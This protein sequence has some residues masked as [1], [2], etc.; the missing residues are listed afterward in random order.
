MR[1]LSAA[2]SPEVSPSQTPDELYTQ[3]GVTRRVVVLCLLLAVFF[4][5]IIPIIDVK[6]QNSFLGAQHLPP[7]AIAVLLVLLLV[8]NPLMRLFAR[9]FMFSRNE[10]LTV[11]IACLFSA[12]VPGH[13]AE[14]Y[15]VPNMIGLFYFANPENRW[16]EYWGQIKSWLTPALWS[17][18]G[19]YGEG[20]RRAVEGW[21]LGNRPEEAIPWDAW[22]VPLF[23]WSALI[24]A[25]YVMLGCLSIMLRAQWSERE[26]LAFPLLRLPEEMTQDVDH[27]HIY[28][29]LGRFFR[30]PMMWI[31]FGIA[32]FIQCVNG[33][34]VYFSDVPKI[35]LSL[36]GNFF[37]EAPWNQIDQVPLQVYPIAVGVTFLLTSEVSFSFWF[38]Y[39]F[40]KLQ[41]IGAYY[42]GFMPS[43]QPNALGGQGKIFTGYQHIG[44]Y[45]AYVGII[46]W[47]GR[48]HLTHIVRR[49][50]GRARARD[51]EK[52]EALSYPLAFWGFA[53]SLAFIIAWS[54][55]A[56]MGWGL[57]LWVWLC[58]LIIV[59]GLSRIIA[60]GGLLILESGWQ[61]VGVIAQFF[62]SG[63][64][65]WLSQANGLLPAQLVQS[66]FMVDMRGFLMP[67]FV[68]GFK[69][70]HDHKIRLKPLFALMMGVTFVS[71][72]VGIWT[73]VKL[74]YRD[75]GGL[76]FH[77]F[78]SQIGPRIPAWNTDG[79]LNGSQNVSWLHSFWLA[80]GAL[81]TYGLMLA[82]SRF[83]G[84]PFHPIGLLTCLTSTIH[85]V[86]FSVFV[87]WLC[88]VLVTK[89][90]GIDSY[91]KV[92]PA[93]LGLVLGEVAMLLLW[94]L[95]DAYFGR[96]G[97]M[98]T[99]G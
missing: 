79:L 27:P 97:H 55:A 54:R 88:K 56:G 70:A 75:G 11:Y 17:D 32:V 68:Q 66:T 98:L 3:R 64:G 8:V 58:Y 22:M 92:V 38:F 35:P 7:G 25:M 44:A 50:F 31:G 77:S 90:G 82:R 83:A 6:L 23:A 29:V 43:T 40:I 21:Y 76:T 62:N 5:Y 46:L 12:L 65:T 34:N 52:H 49:A 2:D 39:W 93:A 9:R 48:E 19:T 30:N 91:R 13:G 42:L 84:F 89:F 60:E 72:V 69:L 24:M 81:L 33:L 95:I 14:N 18:G 86:W 80:M 74:G 45:M 28:G 87:G 36:T 78:Y 59:I 53:L 1:V 85:V 73:A 96:T 16:L 37:S 67:S 99:P 94:L 20:G 47:T 26:A 4:G 57:S 61:P 71:F 10:M 41:Y 15:F 63:P 51:D